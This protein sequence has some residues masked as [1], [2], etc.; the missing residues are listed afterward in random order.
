M[1][2]EV[3][4]AVAGTGVDVGVPWHY[5]DPLR[6]QR[7]LAEGAGLI[8]RSNR[9][10]L[11]VTGED[12]LPWLH[13]IC[14]QHVERLADG[15]STESLV[16]SPPGH[17][18][19]HWELTELDAT[20]WLDTE[21]G[22]AVVVLDYLQKMRFLKRVE[23]V[24]VSAGWAVLTLA[25]P[26][27]A[28]V[29]AAAELPVPPAGR[30]VALPGEPGGFVRGRRWPAGA[31]DLLVPR[32]AQ[33]ARSHALTAAGARPVGLWAFEALRVEQRR[34]RLGFETDHRTIPHEVGW[35]GSAVHLQKGCYRG[36]ETV[37]RVQNL[38]KPPRRLVLLHLSGDADELPPAGTPVLSG[39]RAV[40]F[41]GTAVHHYE[42]G[43]IALAVIKRT[44]PD[45]AA[46][47]VAGAP[48][49][50][51]VAAPAVPGA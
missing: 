17:V 43:P 7:V 39:E 41:L 38:G 3:D 25:G 33:A 9:D 15:D 12:R 2:I 11:T 23:P 24:D 18:E 28:D 26:R 42:L 40:G 50:V 44:I 49:A 19:Q 5:G 30:A 13:T 32:A 29:L 20:V 48:V 6:E 22:A 1:S 27:T 21:P 46:L 51:D 47:T 34:P 8:D 36:Q 31:V 45:D 37:A 4:G 16:L 14:S 35:I 10:V